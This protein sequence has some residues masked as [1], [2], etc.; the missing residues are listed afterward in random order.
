VRLFLALNLPP[1]ERQAI[2]AAMAPMRAAARGVSWSTEERLHLTLKFLGE[3]PEHSVDSVG[4]ALGR[5]ITSHAP[6]ALRLAGFGAF[7]NLRAPRIVWLGVENDVKLELLHHDVERACAELGFELDGRAFRPH[8][9]VGRVRDRLAPG[10]ARDLA[11]AARRVDYSG[12]VQVATVD[13]MASE[14][15]PAG[16]R[17]TVLA[18]MPLGGE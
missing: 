12:T 7:P 16:P 5:V 11:T 1:A 6:V 2:L 10:A 9:T 4:E 15:L 13:L 18:A 17:Y 14:L 8:I 3:Q